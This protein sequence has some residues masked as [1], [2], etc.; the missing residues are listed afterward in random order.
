MKLRFTL[1]LLLC[2]W[3]L[4]LVAQFYAPPVDYHDTVQRRFPVEAARVLA[5]IHDGGR[6][7]IAEVTYHA[8]TSAAGETVWS[9][10]WSTPGKPSRKAT[11]RYAEASLR[12]GAEWYRNVWKQLTAPDWQAPKAPAADLGA[13]F[14]EG[15][16]SGGLTRFEGIDSALKQIA[17]DSCPAGAGAA[18]LSGTL[19]QT[20][21]S[22]LGSP[23]TLDGSVLARAAAWLCAAEQET[24]AKVAP[25]WA[26]VMILA[27]R[28]P[29]CAAAWAG[30]PERPAPVWRCWDLLIRQP[31]PGEALATIAEPAN[32]LYAAPLFAA[33]SEMD[34][35][36]GDL[37]RD[38]ANKLYPGEAFGFLLDYGPELNRVMG[39]APYA[40]EFPMRF[41]H[42]WLGVLRGFTPLPG[43]AADLPELARAIHELD[44]KF[45]ATEAPGQGLADLLNR[46]ARKAEGPLIP[47][48]VVTAQDLLIYGWDF[49]GVQL[50]SLHAT[51]SIH[52]PFHPLAR[53]LE[54]RWLA[55][56]SGWTAFNINT[57]G[58]A[59][60]A[61]ETTDRYQYIVQSKVARLLNSVP[62]R[63]W[64]KTP[65]AYARRRWLLDTHRAVD[66]A[67]S[68]EGDARGLA[69]LIRRSIREGSAYALGSL[70]VNTPILN[71]AL[72]GSSPEVMALRQELQRAV[73]GNTEGQLALVGLQFD[74]NRDPFGYAQALERAHWSTGLG[75]APK[76]VFLNYVRANA[77]GSAFRFYDRWHE[78][79]VDSGD[80][81][82]RFASAVFALAVLQAD[83][84]RAHALRKESGVEATWTEALLGE[85][86]A[87]ARKALD[88]QLE[89]FPNAIAAPAFRAL[90]DDFLPLLPALKDPKNPDHA[91]ALDAFPK[92]DLLLLEQWVVYAR[93]HL[94]PVEAVRFFTAPEMTGDRLMVVA[95]LQGDQATFQRLFEAEADDL[96]APRA[97]GVAQP[98]P[99][100]VLLAWLKNLLL[101]TPAPQQEPDLMPPHA[102]PLLLR[103]RE[104]VKEKG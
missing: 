89:K 94:S 59:A 43:D 96:F 17:A 32:R 74:S 91:K 77:P 1:L 26:T 57:R 40:A 9:F 87:A 47:V 63:A 18:R 97:P 101:R 35:G 78:A 46:A 15:A 88:A 16:A 22:Y 33:C 55:Q 51:Y 49:G 104:L 48:A 20:A 75:I 28:G 82:S 10:A 52:P 86:A 7:G 11:V 99:R 3:P 66:F 39:R 70:L 27:G 95:A 41:L 44:G 53:E 21:L 31:G 2:A 8:E 4:S 69:E 65:E 79:A 50:A 58:A 25:E 80:A 13:A 62:P 24:G 12:G 84:P 90:R 54:S 100:A 23:V 81:K 38:L 42:D 29:E 60:E 93:A 5:W 76:A 67:Q 19:V 102:R 68:H 61:L 34:S 37:F 98:G 56:V 14:W 36:Y 6:P 103:L 72:P 73:P 71:R 45:S 83:A 30:R 92:S 64:P 85:D